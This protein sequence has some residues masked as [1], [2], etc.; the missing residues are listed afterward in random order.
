MTPAGVP[1]LARHPPSGQRPSDNG[2]KGEGPEAV[3]TRSLRSLLKGTV[4]SLP[5]VNSDTKGEDRPAN[6]QGMGGEHLFPST[7]PG[8]QAAL[9][10]NRAQHPV[11]QEIA[12]I[13]DEVR[14]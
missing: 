12:D 3:S 13:I 9:A 4:V 11:E 8:Y 5:P 10:L 1:I 6:D 2:T 7:D 14:A